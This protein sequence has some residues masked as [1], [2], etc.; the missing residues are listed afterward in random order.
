MAEVSAT[1][2]AM[3]AAMDVRLDEAERALVRFELDEALQKAEEVL[4]EGTE[5]LRMAAVA[6]AV[7]ALARKACWMQVRPLME[8][9]FG[10]FGATPRDVFLLWTSV[11]V[12]YERYGEVE[13]LVFLYLKELSAKLQDASTKTRAQD[14]YDAV[15]LFMAERGLFQGEHKIEEAEKKFW[16]VAPLAS[17]SVRGKIRDHLQKN[18]RPPE[19]KKKETT[20]S[21]A[22]GLMNLLHRMDRGDTTQLT[23]DANGGTHLPPGQAKSSAGGVYL[24]YALARVR[25]LKRMFDE[26]NPTVRT[27]VACALGALFMYAWMQ[28]QDGTMGLVTRS[29]AAVARICRNVADLVLGS[30]RAAEP[31]A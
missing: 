4:R 20:N 28:E 6:V 17:E 3:A 16:D 9:T 26:T 2:D 31:Q 30:K 22:H 25:N 5:G 23:R 21:D 12:G 11:E 10:S 7:Q 1:G 8:R 27:S 29:R 13:G 14:D 19:P 24:E 18:L 15:A